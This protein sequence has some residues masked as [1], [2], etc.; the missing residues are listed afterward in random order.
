MVDLIPFLPYNKDM[1]TSAFLS[2]VESVCKEHNIDLLLSPNSVVQAGNISCS[3]YFVD[4]PKKELAVAMGKPEAEWLEILAHEFSHL[5]QYLDKAEVWNNL[6]IE[7]S[8]IKKT[9]VLD[10]WLGGQVELSQNQLNKIIQD[11]VAV[12]LDC[13][14]RTIKAIRQYKLPIDCALYVQKASSYLLFY[15]V[16]KARRKWSIAGKAPYQIPEIVN[17]LPDDF[18]SHDDYLWNPPEAILELIEKHCF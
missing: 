7:G 9:D 16:V 15:H 10:L 2:Q 6:S 3:G 12:E 13:E 8:H 18:L 4:F 14:I 17:A 11:I 5:N 1:K